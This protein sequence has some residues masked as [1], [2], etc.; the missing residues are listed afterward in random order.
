MRRFHLQ[1]FKNTAGSFRRGLLL[2]SAL[3]YLAGY[4]GGDTFHQIYHALTGDHGAHQSD[5]I[6]WVE[7]ASENLT[8]PR[9]QPPTCDLLKHLR[10]LSDLTSITPPA[11]THTEPLPAP[12]LH[13]I[14]NPLPLA[15][16]ASPGSP[17]APPR[18]HV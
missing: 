13:G 8:E 11:L 2:F 5:L 18:L 16:A 14:V 15:L 6:S 17:R 3:A 12:Q 4:G 1:I 7:A 9:T 10:S